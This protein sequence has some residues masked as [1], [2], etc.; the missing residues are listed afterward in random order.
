M[1]SH[2]GFTLNKCVE[3]FKYFAKV[4]VTLSSV[5]NLDL[6]SQH[7]RLRLLQVAKLIQV[8]LS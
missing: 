6:N 5:H 4:F 1:A 7:L 3:H 8:D 2:S